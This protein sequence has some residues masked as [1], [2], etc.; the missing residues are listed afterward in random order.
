MGLETLLHHPQKSFLK[1]RILGMDHPAAFVQNTLNE[2][3]NNEIH[4]KIR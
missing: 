4:K 3:I 1:P 2:F